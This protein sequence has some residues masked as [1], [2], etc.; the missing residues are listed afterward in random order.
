MQIM[1]FL[2][3]ANNVSNSTSEYLSFCLLVPWLYLPPTADE[4]FRQVVLAAVSVHVRAVRSAVVVH[5]CAS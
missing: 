5:C 1:R 3:A 4:A 2:I